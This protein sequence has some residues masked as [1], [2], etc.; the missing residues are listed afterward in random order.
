MSLKYRWLSG[1]KLDASES[2]VFYHKA[3]SCCVGSYCVNKVID[4]QKIR[5]GFGN[6]G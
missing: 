1:D 2:K 4:V 5:C 6:G 3:G